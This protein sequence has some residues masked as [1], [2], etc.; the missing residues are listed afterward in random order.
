MPGKSKENNDDLVRFASSYQKLEDKMKALAESEGDVFLP[1]PRPEGPV[2]YILIC[3]EPSFGSWAQSPEQAKIK[4][5][6]GFRNFVSSLEDFIVHFCACRFLCRP[7]QRYHMTDFSKGA[8]LVQHAEKARADRYKRWYSLLLEEI[9]LLAT[10]DT[11]F[12]AVGKAVSDQLKEESFSRPLISVMHYSGQAAAARARKV[13]GHE[14]EF[15]VFC[16]SVFLQDLLETAKQV[17]ETAGVP[18]EFSSPTLLQVSKANL[19]TS[20]LQ[21]MFHYKTVFQNASF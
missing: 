18:E 19:T 1:N 10:A 15:E 17:L 6:N 11:K 20:R 13:V 7:G 21:L 14:E 4:V 3:M 12:I 8:M 5:K 9:E 2:D 16:K